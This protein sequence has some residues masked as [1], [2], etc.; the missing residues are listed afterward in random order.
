MRSLLQTIQR[1]LG[2]LDRAVAWLRE[3]DLLLVSHGLLLLSASMYLGTGGSIAFFQI[4]S[5]GE[6][7][8]DNY[9]AYIVEPVAR[10]TQFFTVMTMVMYVAAVIMLV[11]ERRSPMRWIPA[12]V[13]VLLTGST[14]VTIYLIFPYNQ[15]MRDGIT[16]PARLHVV[17]QDWIRVNWFRFSLWWAMW[18]CLGVYYS[19]RL[20]Q[21]LR[22]HA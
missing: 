22:Q 17:L 16:D 9:A 14:L 12:A 2:L 18:G 1:G 20:R 10:A 5:F 11:A 21:A 7:T 3:H 13:L 15:E 4:P 19:I 6:F 8:V